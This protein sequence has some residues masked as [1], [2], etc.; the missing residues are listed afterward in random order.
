MNFSEFFYG[1]ILSLTIFIG[2]IL[3]LV[4]LGCLVKN[5]I[6]TKKLSLYQK[7][8]IT[9]N[10]LFLI[11]A[12]LF[13]VMFNNKKFINSS[14]RELTLKNVIIA[15]NDEKSIKLFE[16]GSMLEVAGSLEKG[17]GK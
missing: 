1:F 17:W 13:L 16:D 4:L 9:I 14:T 15:S 10:V 7:L 6:E 2:I 8:I 3:I 12:V 11:C 5:L